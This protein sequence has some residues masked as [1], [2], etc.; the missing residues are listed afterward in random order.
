MIMNDSYPLYLQR[1][2]SP[3]P[4]EDSILNFLKWRLAVRAKAMN[5]NGTTKE[6][7]E[8]NGG[9][10]MKSTIFTLRHIFDKGFFLFCFPGTKKR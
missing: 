8:K 5:P 6:E 3:K 2:F 1:T 9:R 10:S 7:T 4:T